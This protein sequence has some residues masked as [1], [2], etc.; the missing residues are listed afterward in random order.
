MA[1]SES[2]KA[3]RTALWADIAVLGVALVW[4]A[5]YPVAKGALAYMPVLLLIFYRFALTALVMTA[6]A[7]RDLRAIRRDDLLAGALLGSILFAIF[8]AETWGVSMT[9]A[10]NTALIISLCTIFTPFLEFGLQRRSPP[11]GVIAGAVVAVAGVMVLSGGM[12]TLGTGDLLV[13]CAAGLRAVM[14]VST[15]RLMHGRS[16]SS[17]ALTAIQA[18]TV[19]GLTMAVILGQSGPAGLLVEADIGGWAAVAFLALFCTVGAFYVQNAAVRRTSPTRVS[20]LMGTEPLFGFALAWA[21]LSEPATPTAL[22]GA[23]LIVGGTF[24]GL[25]VERH[26]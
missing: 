26:R 4:G 5:S 23:G 25:A 7:H 16:L 22:I 11:A 19:A 12:G 9:S 18:A 3:G 2:F 8:L 21:L 10:T 17:A 15:K 6:V 1:A 14:V 20:F 13:L 24:L